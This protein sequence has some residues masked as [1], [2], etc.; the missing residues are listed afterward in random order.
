MGY[1]FFSLIRGLSSPLIIV[2]PRQRFSSANLQN[3]IIIQLFA[4]L[5]NFQD[6]THI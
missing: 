5:L 3:I 2:P 4:N 6:K 1:Y